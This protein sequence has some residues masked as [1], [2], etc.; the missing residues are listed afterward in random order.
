MTY[1][2]VTHL[3]SHDMAGYP[4]I[5]FIMVCSL[6]NT[7]MLNIPSYFRNIMAL[8]LSP[9][10]IQLGSLHDVP[11]GPLQI[12]LDDVVCLLATII[13]TCFCIILCA[14]EVEVLGEHPLTKFVDM[15]LAHGYSTRHMVTDYGNISNI[16]P[17]NRGTLGLIQLIVIYI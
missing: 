17:T 8:R 11:P 14:E 16:S 13:Y 2:D 3:I 15:G 10:Y 5:S 6:M 4:L 1:H 9:S 12:R 7:M